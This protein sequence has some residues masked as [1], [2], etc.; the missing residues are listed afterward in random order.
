M[1]KKW[2]NY[3]SSFVIFSYLGNSYTLLISG[4][5][6][7]NKRSFQ[8]RLVFLISGLFAFLNDTQAESEVSMNMYM[9]II[10]I[11]ICVD[12]L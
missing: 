11:C 4:S 2:E 5:I 3:A 6:Y 9:Y 7:K 10:C 8:F 1:T 12:H